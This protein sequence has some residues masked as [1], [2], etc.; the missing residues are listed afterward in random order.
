M[1][2][3]AN[4]S[5]ANTCRRKF[6]L[7]L[8]AGLAL[9]STL[10][11]LGCGDGTSSDPAAAEDEAIRDL[12]AKLPAFERTAVAVAVTL[13][14]SSGVSLATTQLVTANNVSQVADDGS[15][16]AVS[17]GGAPQMAYLFDTDGRLLLMGVI[18]ADV[19]TRLDAR[20]T[21]EALVLLVSGVALQ[22]D[23]MELAVRETL[24]SHPIVEPV[25]LAVE[26]A[27][28][29][30]G[31]DENDAALMAALDAAVRA[32]HAVPA[33][34]ADRAGRKQALG[35]E[36]LPASAQSG[37]TVERTDDYNTVV[38]RNAFRR[39]THVWV[40]R[41][42][43]YDATGQ[44]V[45]LPAPVELSHFALGGTTALSF[46]NLVIGVGDYLA[47]LAEDI[48]FIGA[49]ERGNGWWQPVTSAPLTLPVEPDAATVSVYRTRVVGI[50]VSD[51]LPMTGDEAAKLEEI[52]GATLWEDI[53]LPLIKTLIL[54]MISAK[55]GATYK[56]EFKALTSALL[57]SATV[58]LAKIEVSGRYL[59]DTVAALRR[60]DAAAVVGQFFKEFFASGTWKRILETGLRAIVS[61]TPVT[62][63]PVIRDGAG[64][65]IGVNLLPERLLI[66]ANVEQ[67]SA[68]LSKLARIITIAKVITTA[69]DY[70]AM[71]KDWSSSS[72][73]DEF[74][75][76]VSKATI[77]LTPDPVTV[78]GVAVQF[79]VTAQVEGLDAALT[80]DNVW[81]H[82]KCSGRYG[83]LYKRGGDGSNDFESLLTNAAHDY[84]PAGV[85]D[86]P[87]LPD[88]IEVTAFYRNS[89]TNQRIEMGSDSVQVK[90]KKAFSLKITPTGPLDVPA[91]SS[92]GVA[93]AFNEALPTGSTV[94]WVWSH[95]GAGAIE[96]PASDANPAD[97][98]VIFRSA[99]DE[100]AATVRVRAT[101]NLPAAGSAP[102]RRVV[103]GPVSTTLNVKR[104]L[105]TITVDGFWQL[106][107]GAT[108]L[109]PPTCFVSN[110]NGAELCSLGHLNSWV[111]YIVPKVAGA[112]SYVITIYDASGGIRYTYDVPS[113]YEIGGANIQDGGSTLRIPY[114][115]ATNPYGSYNGV[116]NYETVQANGSGYIVYRAQ[117]DGPTVRAVVT[118]RP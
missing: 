78:D 33:R 11:L 52:M 113:R 28:A 117:T 66:A 4:L 56:E 91:D 69:G 79:A 5:P 83:A 10:G 75:L 29:R 88:T 7:G 112:L 90:F 116:S 49:Y 45:Q 99:S 59:P 22:G 85:D 107:Q 63:L 115:A 20:T 17:L 64:A 1:N 34:S 87:D 110:A 6:M 98:S 109:N 61:A 55:V 16:G 47:E 51:G 102:A 89:T 76:N 27:A 9:A 31:I 54:P 21:A 101:V 50:G 111:V 62:V 19:N 24:R 86:D 80:A 100:G 96:A 92:L 14:A 2:I 94:D 93:A 106:E 82:W 40:S 67:L 53:C 30:A 60:G 68:S 36:V 8:P 108:P 18:E 39:R 104:G 32:M 74:T 73:L 38:L 42:G 12:V 23:A 57:L 84:I 46:D 118:L 71:A 72:R 95:A 58:D 114:W 48:G 103:V 81:L 77:S 44:A 3:P 41:V 97:S 13:P 26:A 65:I 70:A 43:H 35:V 15:A 37:V 105:R 25:R